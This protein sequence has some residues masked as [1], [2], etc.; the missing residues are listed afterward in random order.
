MASTFRPSRRNPAR[1]AASARRSGAG[2]GGLPYGAVTEALRGL[3][4]QVGVAELRRLAGEHAGEL[5]WLVPGLGSADQPGGAE[6]VELDASYSQLQ[7]FE[8]VLGLVGRLAAETP[9]AV[10]VEDAHW[11]DASTRDLLVFLAHNLQQVGVVVAAT[12]RTDELHRQHP[13]WPVLARL[14]RG[15]TVER[16]D[17]A[18][19]D[20]DELARLLEGILGD[21]PGPE[22]LERVLERSQGNASFAE[23]LLAAGEAQD[24]Q[25]PES[26]RDLL[27]VTIDGL[28]PGVVE[29]VRVVAAAGGTARHGLV[30]RVVVTSGGSQ[31]DSGDLDG[32]LR[33]AVEQGVLVTDAAAGT[34]AFRHPQLPPS[35]HPRHTSRGTNHSPTLDGCRTGHDRCPQA[36]R[37]HHPPPARRTPHRHWASSQ[38]GGGPPVRGAEAHRVGRGEGAVGGDVSDDGPAPT[39]TSSCRAWSRRSRGWLSLRV[40]A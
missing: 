15:E 11:A 37:H 38:R 19:F 2:D 26:L 13:L 8:A 6:G 16:I 20:R 34:Y 12:Y 17:L 35:S 29:V 1:A 31:P 21:A 23:E 5:Q 4:E 9:L 27:L 40:R 10:V 7:L 24:A 18:P 32:A 25:L 22:L 30:A 28:S 39:V 3:A 33:V 14:V 36:A